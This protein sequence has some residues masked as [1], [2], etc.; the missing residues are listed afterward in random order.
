[1]ALEGNLRDFSL[2]HVFQLINTG[3]KTG[4]LHIVRASG[5]AEA[6][7]YFRKGR[8]FGAVSN[9]NRKPIGERLVQAGQ[10]TGEQLEGALDNQK[11]GKQRRKLGQILVAEGLLTTDILK[12]FV[13]EQIQSTVFDLLPWEEGEFQF[14]SELPPVEDMGLLV[15]A[16]KVL[17]E[18]SQRLDEW[19]KVREKVPSLGAVFSIN[20]MAIDNTSITL[21][22]KHLKLIRHIN[23]ERT[24][25]ELAMATKMSEFETCQTLYDLVDAAVVELTKDLGESQLSPTV[26]QPAAPARP[27]KTEPVSQ[28]VLSN[29]ASLF[30]A[31]LDDEGLDGMVA[32]E[33]SANRAAFVKELSAVTHDNGSGL[34]FGLAGRLGSRKKVNAG[35][36]EHDVNEAIE[37]FSR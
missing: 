28:Q 17:S 21:T 37:L 25:T 33:N 24:V 32:D 31:E 22:A 9:F 23:G 34:R 20:E 10:I 35:I 11:N 5:G 26:V 4:T 29:A 6:F 36:S 15:S 19:D 18:G 16:K 7:V 14:N 30:H 13:R 3:K 8:I 27:A 1:M 12:Q 2:E